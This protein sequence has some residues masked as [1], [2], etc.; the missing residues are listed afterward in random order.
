[1]KFI[2]GR[3]NL[4]V[5][6]YVP[7]PCPN[8][9]QFCTS[10][11][12]YDSNDID[13]NKIRNQLLKVRNSCIKE[14]VFTGGE[15][16]T[17]LI[18]LRVLIDIVNNKDVYI[19]TS[20]INENLVEFVKL[21]NTKD[22]IK[23]VNISRHTESYESDSKILKN[24]APDVVVS[25]ISKPV[26][27]NVVLPETP[28]V[29]FLNGVL[30][31]WAEIKN[32][33]VCFRANFNKTTPSELH[34]LTDKTLIKLLTL[35][36]YVARDYCDVCDTTIMERNKKRYLYHR[37]LETT[38]VKLGEVIQVNDIIV[39]P[40]GELCYDWDKKN[41]DIDIMKRSF[42]L[43]QLAPLNTSVPVTTANLTRS[44]ERTCGASFNRCGGL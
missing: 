21:V 22:C 20:L 14:V 40:N 16:M 18:A 1:M 37:G 32:T 41:E 7:Y 13:F 24:I 42:G 10:K 29:D 23:G 44:M 30:N 19:N 5:T 26:K 34:S 43:K 31:R 36:D 35:G 39:F 8:D 6:V 11:K 17:N 12:E 2:I 15:P 27:I 3:N 4:S 33:N 25:F 28:S 38:S 9:C